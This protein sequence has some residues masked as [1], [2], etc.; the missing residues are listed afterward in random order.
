MHPSPSVVPLISP[1]EDKD[2]SQPMKGDN[3]EM[4]TCPPIKHDTPASF[5]GEPHTALNAPLSVQR[6]DPPVEAAAVKM[7]DTDADAITSTTPA[8]PVTSVPSRAVS[9]HN[10]DD[11]SDSGDDDDAGKLVSSTAPTDATSA[12][13]TMLTDS[14]M[15]GQPGMS[16][17]TNN[18]TT[19]IGRKDKSARVSC[20]QCKT[21]KDDGL[22]LFCTTKAEKGKRKRKC[23]KK[24]VRLTGT[25]ETETSAMPFKF[26]FL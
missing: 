6:A 24:Y 1:V 13:S 26:V 19:N 25:F 3:D 7:E 9:A 10:S 2:S 16:S 18:P 4:I 23:R 8:M 11:D 21:T 20:H 15:L 12:G 22:L 17:T 14:L 5:T